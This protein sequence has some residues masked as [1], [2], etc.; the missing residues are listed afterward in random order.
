MSVPRHRRRAVS[1]R[2]KRYC[3][4]AVAGLV[5]AL[6]AGAL[7]AFSGVMYRFQLLSLSEAF[8]VLRWA[9]YGGV[10]G[11]AVSAIGLARVRPG[12]SR[13]GLW[14]AL[15]GL[16]VAA[17]VFWIPFSH[18]RLARDVPAIHDITTDTADP[19]EFRAVLPLRP[20]HA[21]NLEYGGESLARQQRRAY[22]DIGPAD[23]E[24]SPA[25]VFDAASATARD[26]GWRI[27]DASRGE[28]RIEAVAT[29]LWFGFRDD[30]VIRLRNTDSGTRVDVRSVSRV[31]VSDVGANARRI[32]EFMSALKSRV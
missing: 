15:A 30:V 20:Q 10:A 7:G 9:A 16:A 24:A 13:K 11:M 3:G 23:F 6:F 25:R 26:M 12:A 29:T 31:G 14:P 2:G 27:V 19:P 22:P 8:T 17:V 21:N 5:V 18:Q 1:Q 4:Y 28:G 32:S